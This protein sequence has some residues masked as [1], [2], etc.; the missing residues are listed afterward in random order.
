MDKVLPLIVRGLALE[1]GSVRLLDRIDTT[2]HAPGI[3]VVMGPNGAGKSLFLKCLHGLQVP[4]AG[5]VDWSGGVPRQAMVFQRPVLLR[6][7]VAAN[8]EF[9]TKDRALRDRLLARVDLLDKARRPAR[10]LSGGEQQRLAFARA[11]ATDPQVMFLDEPTAGLD[12]ASTAQIET[13]VQEA[14][15][16][17]TKIIFVT[18]D[19][20]QARRLAH[21]VISCT[22]VS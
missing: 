17:G 15:S 13:L 5:S 22:K 11:L 6:R 7:S 12:P 9:V 21:D 4:T 1:R 8:L 19:I 18:H 14:Q 10:A 2:I 20:G 16:E 3:T